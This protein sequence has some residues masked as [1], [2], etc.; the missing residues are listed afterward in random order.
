MI[1][2]SDNEKREFFEKAHPCVFWIRTNALI[3]DYAYSS[4]NISKGLI[5]FN[6]YSQT[7]LLARWLN[8]VMK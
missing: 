4:R 3:S 6:Q 8:S 2:I 1:F 5:L 7:L